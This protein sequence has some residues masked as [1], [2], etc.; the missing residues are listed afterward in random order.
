MF[1]TN[2]NGS[3]DNDEFFFNSLSPLSTERSDIVDEAF[4]KIDKDR[5]GSIDAKDLKDLYL[6][7]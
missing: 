6:P 5:S 2:K 3:I 7:T 1:D 4:L